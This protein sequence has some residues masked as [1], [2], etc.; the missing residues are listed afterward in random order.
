MTQTLPRGLAKCS[1]WDLLGE[2]FRILF[3]NSFV[4]YVLD[5]IS[6]RDA[7]VTGA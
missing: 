6:P 1:E 3:H 2:S 7:V 5:S 4:G